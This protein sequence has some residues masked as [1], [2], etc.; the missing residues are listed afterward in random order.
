MDLSR[1]VSLGIGLSKISRVVKR[2]LCVRAPHELHTA[3]KRYVHFFLRR[4]PFKRSCG[5]IKPILL[6]DK[7]VWFGGEKVSPPKFGLLKQYN[8]G[9]ADPLRF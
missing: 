7:L 6:G 3:S 2:I 8:F 5:R 1:S 9:E 4:V